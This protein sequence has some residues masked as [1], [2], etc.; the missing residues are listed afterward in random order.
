MSITVSGAPPPRRPDGP[1]PP[2]SCSPA[3]T[4]VSPRGQGGDVPEGATS[5]LVPETVESG[6][7][8]LVPA[9]WPQTWPRARHPCP[10]EHTLD[11]HSP[12]G[13]AGQGIRPAGQS[14]STSG[15]Q[16]GAQTQAEPLVP[17]ASFPRR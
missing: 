7:L 3:E 9:T 17:R 2:N 11:L 1:P 12:R 15:E 8:G 10:G 13:R 16:T 4:D 5:T 6:S 14:H